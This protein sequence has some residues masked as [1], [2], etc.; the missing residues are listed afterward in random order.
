ML[1]VE[2]NELNQALVQGYLR[3]A[4]IKNSHLLNAKAHTHLRRN[5]NLYTF[6]PTLHASNHSPKHHL[7]I[8]EMLGPAVIPVPPV[9]LLPKR[10][11]SQLPLLALYLEYLILN[12]VLHD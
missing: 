4:R 2:T 6:I 8:P 1:N 11:T 12:R 5:C 3:K 10:Q 7:N 9:L